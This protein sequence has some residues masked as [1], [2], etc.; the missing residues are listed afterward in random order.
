MIGNIRVM[1][2]SPMR[3]TSGGEDGGG[4]IHGPEHQAGGGEV[5]TA[6]GHDAEDFSAVQGE[7]ALRHGHTKPGDAG[8]AAGA[9]HVVE[10]GAGVKVMAAAGAS[11]D[12]G[13]T[14]VAAVGES[15]STETD[16][17]V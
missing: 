14:A 7:V 13:A 17:Q 4:E 1:G 9:G 8:E 10:A 15:G 16:D 2:A 11:A 3:G 5:D 12:G 6:G